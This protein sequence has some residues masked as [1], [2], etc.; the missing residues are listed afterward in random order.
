M[1][2]YYGWYIVALSILALMLTIGSTMNSYGMYVLPASEDLGLSRADV[3]TGLILINLGMAALAP[4]VGR[5]LDI[6]PI[7][8]IMCGGAL[9]FGASFLILGLSHNVWLSAFALA[10]PLP[11]GI[12]GIGHLAMTTVVARWFKAQLGRAMALAMMGMSAGTVVMAP[13]I[14][15]LIEALGWRMCLIVLGGAFTCVFLVIVLLVRERPGP[16]DIEPGS[17]KIAPPEGGEPVQP[18]LGKPLAVM[19]LLRMPIFWVLSLSVALCLSV[20]QTTVISIVPIAQEGGISVTKA[21]T[22]LSVLG[23]CSLAGKALLAVI[24]DWIDRVFSLS[25]IFVF[26]G[27][28]SGALLLGNSYEILLF[29]AAMQGLAAAA[30]TPIFMALLAE[31]I[32]AASFGTA[33][34]AAALIM[35]VS[36]AIMVRLGGEIYDRTGGYDAMFIAFV[37]ISLVAAVLVLGSKRLSGVEAV[38]APA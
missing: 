6:Y 3:N 31:R 9:M 30:I 26:V 24:G 13:T 4:I 8:W 28:S 17:E 5:M 21:A 16:N 33:N 32:G 36:A 18:A 7:R 19:E 35:S 27:L 22:L 23:A 20:L 15:Y 38:S 29:C 11:L 34:G 37:A 10:L 12:A 2:I 25:L 1:R 14:G